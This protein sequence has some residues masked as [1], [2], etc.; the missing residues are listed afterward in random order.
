MTSDERTAIITKLK[1]I[2][3]LALEGESGEKVTAE[4]KIQELCQK[5]NVSLKD[6]EDD[7]EEMVDA[8][9]SYKT[10]RESALL[11]Q[12]IYK[13][14]GLEE[15]YRVYSESWVKQK[16]YKIQ[17]TV[18]QQIEIEILYDFYKKLYKKEEELFYQAFTIKHNIYPESA[19]CASSEK[20][21]AETL[22]KMLHL[23]MGLSD[24]EPD[25]HKRITTKQGE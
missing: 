24:D 14:T 8:F 13:V 16:K 6:L 25:T 17:C 4:A 12:I 19:N 7:R 10:D 23:V 22:R 11:R 20:P 9:F 15:I 1:K 2:Y 18:S 3:T 21:D 5:Y